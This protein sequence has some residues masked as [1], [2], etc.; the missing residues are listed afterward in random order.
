MSFHIRAYQSADFEAVY[1]I[2]LK[3]GDAG[4]DATALYD[5][6]NI[7]GHLYVGPYVTLSPE[8]AFVLEDTSGVCGYVL[9]ALDSLSFYEHM[10]TQWLPRIQ[11]HVPDPTG[12]PATWTATERLYHQI[13]HPK[14]TLPKPL[15]AY[16]SHL[17]IDLLPR[18]QRQ[19]NGS[20]MMAVLLAELNAQGSQAVHLGMDPDNERALRFY[21]KLGFARIEGLS[22]LNGLYLGKQL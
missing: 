10:R 18:A 16:P 4:N 19:G 9:G 12:D 21:T 2:C 8:L 7:L 15:H 13:H 11:S 22:N 6:P 14:E 5:D 3:T 1:E 17:H 20:K